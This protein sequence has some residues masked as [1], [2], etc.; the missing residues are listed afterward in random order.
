MK[1]LWKWLRLGKSDKRSKT[2]S[3][4][5]KLTRISE[6]E[7]EDEWMNRYNLRKRAME[8]RNEQK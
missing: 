6:Q 8:R 3:E 7:I 1:N 5:K 4:T 2:F